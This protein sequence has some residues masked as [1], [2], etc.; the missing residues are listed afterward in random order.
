MQN[1]KKA[2]AVLGAAII[3][4]TVFTGCGTKKDTTKTPDPAAITAKLQSE[5][6][7]PEMIGIK[8]ER[9]TKYYKVPGESVKDFSAYVCSSSASADEI[10]VFKAANASDAAKI[11]TAVESR[12]NMKADEYQKYGKPQECAN[13]K[14]CVLETKGNYVVFAITSDNKNAQKIVESFF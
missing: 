3:M 11:E 4:V 14:D 6:K 2:A 9:L 12:K 10:A 5:I 7:F 1:L 13:I 8:K